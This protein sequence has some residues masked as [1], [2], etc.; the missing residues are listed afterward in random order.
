MADSLGTNVKPE[1]RFSS[2][3]RLSLASI[4]ELLVLMYFMMPFKWEIQGMGVAD[5]E[6]AFHL[7]VPYS[8]F[9]ITIS[10]SII[11]PPL[12]SVAC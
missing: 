2:L 6:L 9:V 12:D 10:V 5:L 1:R 3:L 7:H 8:I 11:A 4:V